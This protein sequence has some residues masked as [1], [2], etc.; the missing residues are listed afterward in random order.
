M[1]TPAS[2]LSETITVVLE[3]SLLEFKEANKKERKTLIARVARDTLPR[4]ANAVTHKKVCGPSYFIHRHP[5]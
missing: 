4:D 1:S 5:V 3:E 2:G